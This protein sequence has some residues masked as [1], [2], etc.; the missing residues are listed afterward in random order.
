MTRPIS[1]VLSIQTAYP[2]STKAHQGEMIWECRRVF[3]RSD[4]DRLSDVHLIAIASRIDIV[5]LSPP[6]AK[7]VQ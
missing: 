5:E 7:W 6:S 1:G 4:N 2:N 3:S